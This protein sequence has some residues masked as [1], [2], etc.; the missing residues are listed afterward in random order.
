MDVDKY[1]LPTPAETDFGAGN[2]AWFAGKVGFIENWTDLGVR[3]EDA[4]SDS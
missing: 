4:K 1:A 3:S 2:S